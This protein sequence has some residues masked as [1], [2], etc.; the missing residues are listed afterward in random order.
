MQGG[1]G[2]DTYT[3]DNVGDVVTENL[4]EGTD[5][6]NSAITY[7]LGSN[8]ENLTL[9]GSGT[10]NGT[11]NEFNNA[12]TGNT[13]NNVLTG[14]AGNDTLDGGTG[15][16]TLVGGVGNDS[17]I[18]D[19]T[20][21]VVTENLT[22]G[23]DTVKASATFTLSANIET[24]ILTGAA[25]MDGT[26]NSLNNSL[27]GNDYNNILNGGAGADTMTGA[28]GDDTYV[29]DDAGDTIVEIASGGT[30]TVQSSINYTLG[31]ELENLTLTG[32]IATTATG[33]GLNNTIIGNALANVMSG[34]AGNDTLKGGAGNDSLQGEAG[35]DNL[36]GEA[37]NDTLDG[38]AGNDVLTGGAGNDTYVLGRGYGAETVTDNDTTA[39]NTDV[40][41]F[42]SGISNDQIWFRKVNTNDLEVSVIGTSDKLTL[43]SWYLGNQYHVEQFKTADGKLL[44]DSD[45]QKL[46]DAMAAFAPPAAGQS[47]L[48]SNYQTTLNPVLAANWH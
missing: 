18:V 16:D 2:N 41:S 24:L 10:I 9:T 5:K 32:S 36:Q 35:A 40:A 28:V 29:V 39:G 44:L 6:V 34:G 15:I 13:G 17:Y 7:T 23:V 42:M 22:E 47:T 20:S 11:G 26:G 4:N 31:N 45:V 43:K 21:D 46:V 38:G 12:L 48:P 30:D 14:L 33:N 27:T 25:A 8:L 19:N 37:G 1:I 3:V